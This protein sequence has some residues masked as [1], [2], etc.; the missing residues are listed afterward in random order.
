MTLVMVTSAKKQTS[1]IGTK[2]MTQHK[3]LYMFAKISQV[4]L[5]LVRVGI[6]CMFI[7]SSLPKIR[8]PYDFL[9]SVYSYELVGPKLGMFV[10]MTLPWLELLVGI[11]LIGGIFISGALLISIALA[12]MFSYVLGSAL[13]KGL[14]ITCGCF[15]VG[16]TELVTYTTFTRAFVILIVSLA[17]YVCE[18]LL[19]KKRERKGDILI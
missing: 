6:G 13:H 3:R 2:E 4:F 11:C 5:Y 16:S 7:W 8:Q 17:A 12:A 19:G 18:I 14:E 9:S 1:P 15:G 10:A